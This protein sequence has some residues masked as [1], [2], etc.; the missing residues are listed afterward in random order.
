LAPAKY[1]VAPLTQKWMPQ[2]WTNDDDAACARGALVKPN[3]AMDTAAASMIPTTAKLRDLDL[4]KR[5]SDGMGGPANRRIPATHQGKRVC[6]SHHG[7]N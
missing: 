4:I 2:R 5:S 3:V 6:G 1:A 7:R